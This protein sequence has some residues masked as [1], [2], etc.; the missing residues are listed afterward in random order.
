VT[1]KSFTTIDSAL[2]GYR[3]LK[4]RG[5]HCAVVSQAQVD[6]ELRAKQ[7]TSWLSEVAAA[8][9]AARLLVV[10]ALVQVSGNHSLGNV[11]VWREARMIPAWAGLVDVGEMEQAERRFRAFPPQLSSSYLT[12]EEAELLHRMGAELNAAQFIQLTGMLR[13]SV[14]SLY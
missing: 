6:L 10:H 14:L 9:P 2:Q 13:C 5:L 7:L 12:R 11:Q 3:R 1:V 8:H 4:S